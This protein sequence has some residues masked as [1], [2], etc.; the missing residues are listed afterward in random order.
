MPVPSCS[1]NTRDPD[2]EVWTLRPGG[3]DLRP[4]GLDQTHLHSGYKTRTGRHQLLSCLASG[5]DVSTVVVQY[6]FSPLD[7]RLHVVLLVYSD[8]LNTSAFRR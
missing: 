8:P 6:P 3:L 5:H 1:V 7:G 2:Q 4:G